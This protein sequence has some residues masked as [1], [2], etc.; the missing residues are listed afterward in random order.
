MAPADATEVRVEVVYCPRDAADADRQE[1]SLPAGSTLRQALQA[2][3]LLSRHPELG[4]GAPVAGVWGRARSLDSVVQEG[5]RVELYRP[6]QVDPK[7][8]RRLRYRG[9]QRAAA[10]R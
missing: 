6:L 4:A 9:Q 5:D 3:G 10:R 2:S 1:L 8:A 7:E